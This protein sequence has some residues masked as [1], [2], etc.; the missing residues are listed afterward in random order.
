MKQSLPFLMMLLFACFITNAQVITQFNWNSNP[1]KKATIGN[2]AISIGSSATVSSN[3]ASGSGLNPGSPVKDIDMVLTGS[4]YNVPGIDISVDFR[5]EENVASFFYR[6][7]V[8]DFGMDNGYLTAKF[9]LKT[10][11]GNQTIH[12]GNIYA[13]PNDHIFHNYRFYYDSLSGKAI[14]SVDGN[15]VYTYTGTA[16]TA[17]YWTADNVIVGR[18]MDAT[19]NNVAILDNLLIQGITVA[20]AT[21]PV[22]LLSFTAE[23]KGTEIITKWSSTKEENMYTYELEHST[24]G[25]HYTTMARVKP[26]NG[27]ST[28]NNYQFTDKSPAAAANY[29]RL[30]MV[31]IDLKYT[32]SDVRVVN[33][34]H[35]KVEVSCYPN[36]VVDNLFIRV[37][38]SN[39][40]AYGYRIATLDG[41]ILVSKTVQLAA[42]AQVINVDMS[43]VNFNGLLFVEV[44]SVENNQQQVFKVIK[45]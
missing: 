17:L 45:K 5:R 23:Q 3:G 39:P 38:A 9:T 42:G 31:D 30:K 2:N 22:K 40:G 26:T 25:I 21:L 29:Y 10:S 18:L 33:G 32:Y 34:S 6:G 24:D 41:K 27:Y 37:S 14:V 8:F 16:K 20:A 19:G 28:I 44:M 12:S 35:T 15:T 43:K 11:D 4:D 7:S 36:P 1:A 13:I